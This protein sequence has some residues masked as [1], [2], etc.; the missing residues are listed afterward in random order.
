MI[1]GWVDGL[2]RLIDEWIDGMIDEWMDGCVGR[3]D[4]PKSG[5]MP[6]VMDGVTSEVTQTQMVEFQLHY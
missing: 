4:G 5:E 6:R 3:T 1:D 2:K